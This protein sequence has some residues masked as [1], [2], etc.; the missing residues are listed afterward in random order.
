MWY[1][2]GDDGHDG[3][4]IT[5]QGSEA[6]P[7]YL[8]SFQVQIRLRPS[9][10]D[11]IAQRVGGTSFSIM[12]CQRRFMKCRVTCKHGEALL[13][14]NRNARRKRIASFAA[15]RLAPARWRLRGRAFGNN[16]PRRN[17][18]TVFP[19]RAAGSLDQLGRACHLA[20]RMCCCHGHAC[21]CR[22]QV[23]RF[24]MSSRPVGSQALGAVHLLGFRAWQPD[25]PRPSRTAP[26]RLRSGAAAP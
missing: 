5:S 23:Q 15:A 10:D 11:A 13:R 2:D 18:S 1:D 12:W 8:P 6:L 14:S 4:N 21:A 26:S 22:A 9:R 24:L 25:R 17:T 20:L 7:D 16:R 3:R 19:R